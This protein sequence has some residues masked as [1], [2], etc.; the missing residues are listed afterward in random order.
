MKS[1]KSEID[2]SSGSIFNQSPS[3]ILELSPPSL[4]APSMNLESLVATPTSPSDMFPEL[5]CPAVQ[6]RCQLTRENTLPLAGSCQ[7]RYGPQPLTMIHSNSQLQNL[8]QSFP[9]NVC[10]HPAHVC[11]PHARLNNVIFVILYRCNAL[12]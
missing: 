5:D 12:L 2:D 1:Y 4:A 8:L 10:M 7:S 9:Q 6:S 11:T 3:S